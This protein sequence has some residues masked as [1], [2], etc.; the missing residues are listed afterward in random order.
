MPDGMCVT[1]F[2][3]EINMIPILACTIHVHIPSTRDQALLLGVQDVQDGVAVTKQFHSI[4]QGLVDGMRNEQPAESSIA[5]HLLDIKDPETG[6]QPL[7]LC[8]P[9]ETKKARLERS[10]NHCIGS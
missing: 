3:D 7:R 8:T 5:A 6:Q 2:D 1:H 10:A 9:W 4:M